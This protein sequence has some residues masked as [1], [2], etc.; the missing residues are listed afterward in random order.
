M[1]TKIF[2]IKKDYEENAKND[3]NRFS[4]KGQTT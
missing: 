4:F 1:R 3:D 2:W